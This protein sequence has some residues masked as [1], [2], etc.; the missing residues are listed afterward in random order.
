M[1]TCSLSHA[2]NHICDPHTCKY[3][4]LH[5][6]T[7]PKPPPDKPPAQLPSPNLPGSDCLKQESR[8][9]GAP[10]D[11]SP[12]FKLHHQTDIK[13]DS[14]EDPL[15]P[16]HKTQDAVTLLLHPIQGCPLLGLGLGTGMS[17]RTVAGCS[18]HSFVTWGE[19]GEPRQVPEA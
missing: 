9:E 19:H 18:L 3:C 7:R 8:E 11:S 4:K 17:G 15:G 1:C 2:C 14:S 5:T 6:H 10:G 16:L 13:K 12:P